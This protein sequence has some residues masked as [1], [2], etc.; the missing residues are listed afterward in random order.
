M[1][2]VLGTFIY[3]TSYNA[4]ISYCT[5]SGFTFFGLVE[6]NY[7]LSKEIL[8]EI[9]IKV[10]EYEKFSYNKFEHKKFEF[11]KFSYNKFEYNRIKIKILRRG[12]IGVN[13]IGYVE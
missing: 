12:V 2:A 13:K 4:V 5:D 8:Q 1:G 7:E 11:K 3:E 9:G 10:F 6:Q